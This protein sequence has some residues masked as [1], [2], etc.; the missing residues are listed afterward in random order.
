[1]RS[2]P[3]VTSIIHFVPWFLVANIST[4]L[5]NWHSMPVGHTVL[6]ILKLTSLSMFIMPLCSLINCSSSALYALALGHSIGLMISYHW[7]L[8]LLKDGWHIGTCA[9]YIMMLLIAASISMVRIIMIVGAKRIVH[10]S[11]R[12]TSLYISATI[13]AGLDYC[14]AFFIPWYEPIS[15]GFMIADA[16]GASA[17]ISIGG[18]LALSVFYLLI[19]LCLANG[20]NFLFALGIFLIACI[21]WVKSLDRDHNKLGYLYIYGLQPGREYPWPEQQMEA[22]YALEKAYDPHSVPNLVIWPER[23]YPYREQVERISRL[24][25]LNANVPF[26]RIIGAHVRVESGSRI[27]NAIILSQQGSGHII[28][29]LKTSAAPLYERGKIATS[30]NKAI[31]GYKNYQLLVPICYEILDRTIWMQNNGNAGITISADL[32]DISNQA[33]LILTKATRLR[34]LECSVP[35]VRVSNGSYSAAFDEEGTAVA[36]LPPGQGILKV[37]VR[38]PTRLSDCRKKWVATSSLLL[39]IVLVSLVSRFKLVNALRNFRSR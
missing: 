12:F 2:K 21:S 22:L 34:A 14:L 7:L 37:L 8:P 1:M 9:A 28:S 26:D 15:I 18:T 39:T 32:Y 30:Q 31:V 38:L 20:R 16:P 6:S 10:N 3:V 23:A 19:A 24:H 36:F 27:A 17:I 25:S 33:S 11:V 13:V 29:R 5:G 4:A 35:F